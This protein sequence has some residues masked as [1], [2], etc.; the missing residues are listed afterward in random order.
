[1]NIHLPLVIL[2]STLVVT[3]AAI[4]GQPGTLESDAYD[5]AQEAGDAFIAAMTGKDQGR[6]LFGPQHGIRS[7]C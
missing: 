5:S 4:G 6:A 1:M 7:P 3:T 2:V